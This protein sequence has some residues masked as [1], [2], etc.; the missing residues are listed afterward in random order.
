M[1]DRNST[2]SA[3][4]RRGRLPHDERDQRRAEILDAALEVLI[5]VGLDQ[6]TMLAVAER[7][8]ASKGT[9]YTWFGDRDGLLRSL[10]EH[11]ADGSAERIA[12]GLD[13]D[14]DPADVLNA[15]A[16]GL[17][18]LL[19]SPASIVLNRAAMDLRRSQT[20][21]SPQVAIASDRSLSVTCGTLMPPTC[22][23][24]PMQ[25]TPFR[26]SMDSSCATSRSAACWARRRQASDR[27]ER[28]PPRQSPSSYDCL[29]IPSPASGPGGMQTQVVPSTGGSGQI[30][31]RTESN[32]VGAPSPSIAAKA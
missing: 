24:S 23:P 31:S 4:R 16:I 12:A 29:P 30:E 3:S 15:Y 17:L 27:F 2:T 25:P 13:Q 7:A 21:C 10:I 19:T 1:T 11:N 18:R 5:E 6:M 9:L 28:K 20:H 32:A 8:G 14:D 22:S 26:F